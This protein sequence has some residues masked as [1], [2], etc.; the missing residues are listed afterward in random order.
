[1]TLGD[2]IGA[3]DAAEPNAC[4]D[5]QKTAWVS[6]CEGMAHTE[7]FLLSP[8]GFRPLNYD[9]DKDEELA[10]LPPHDKIY[11]L[12]LQ[13]KIHFANGEYDRYMNSM[14]L[15]NAAWGEFVRWYARVYS[16]ADRDE[17]PAGAYE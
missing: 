14:A 9:E 17:P 8:S 12:Y 10:V 4:T 5:G 11:P 3:V 13:A 7:V 1:M 2:V 6:E 15:F 16:P